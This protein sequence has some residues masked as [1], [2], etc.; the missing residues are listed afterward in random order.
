MMPLPTA[1]WTWPTS[2]GFARTPQGQAAMVAVPPKPPLAHEGGAAGGAGAG[3]FGGTGGFGGGE[4]AGG[5][6][7]GAMVALGG[8]GSSSSTLLASMTASM[9]ENAVLV[10]KLNER[11]ANKVE[12]ARFGAESFK[13][14][15]YP[16]LAFR[17]VALRCKM[18]AEGD[19]LE[20]CWGLLA[21]MLGEMPELPSGSGAGGGPLHHHPRHHADPAPMDP[22]TFAAFLD[23]SSPPRQ[24]QAAHSKRDR[25]AAGRLPQSPGRSFSNLSSFEV[26]PKKSF[27]SHVACSAH[28]GAQGSGHR[29]RS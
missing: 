27:I 15:L 9:R 2:S 16:A 11:R 19:S 13:A 8:V 10:S 26:C 25:S 14:A 3:G 18:A 28:L 5:L 29:F 20:K 22:G 12:T 24:R 7:A 1:E 23:R 21:G 6:G 17:D 4:A